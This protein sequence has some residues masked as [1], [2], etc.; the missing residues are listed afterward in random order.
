MK[1]D[2]KHQ[3]SGNSLFRRADSKPSWL[4]LEYVDERKDGSRTWLV[5]AL[6][7]NGRL[8]TGT[9][10]AIEQR[11]ARHGI[12]RAALATLN[13]LEL[14]TEHM[15]SCKLTDVAS[16][17]NGSQST[18]V[19]RLQLDSQGAVTDVFGSATIESDFADAAARAVLDAA[20]LFIHSVVVDV[21]D[22]HAA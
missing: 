13:A 18:I 19:V 2:V 1:F 21:N 6:N 11:H 5:V 17:S 10:P 15:V 16:V 7:C 8:I 4:E 22:W 14:F 12:H 3:H 9:S 20:N